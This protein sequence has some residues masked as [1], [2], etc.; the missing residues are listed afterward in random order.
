MRGRV[1]WVTWGQICVWWTQ[2]EERKSVLFK[3]RNQSSS[4]VPALPDALSPSQSS[5]RHTLWRTEAA[6]ACMK[7]QAFKQMETHELIRIY[8]TCGRHYAQ[9]SPMFA[10]PLWYTHSMEEHSHTPSRPFL[11][12]KAEMS[13]WQGSEMVMRPGALCGSLVDRRPKYREYFWQGSKKLHCMWDT[14]PIK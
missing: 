9:F 3:T 14:S 12:H 5:I 2:L 4:P 10:A 6:A 8:S 11:Y 13:Y 1:S 7:T